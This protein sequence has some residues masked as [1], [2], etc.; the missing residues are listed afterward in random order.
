MAFSVSVTGMAAIVCAV[1][2]THALSQSLRQLTQ[3]LGHS[4]YFIL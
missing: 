4:I 2:L 3:Q 1:N